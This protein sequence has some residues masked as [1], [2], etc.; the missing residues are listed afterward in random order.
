MYAVQIFWKA[1]TQHFPTI[2]MTQS[3]KDMVEWYLNIQVL[4]VYLYYCLS[5]ISATCAEWLKNTMYP[6]LYHLNKNE[7]LFKINELITNC[8]IFLWLQRI[9]YKQQEKGKIVL[10]S[11][12]VM[13]IR[14]TYEKCKKVRNILQTHM[15]KYE[16]HDIFMSRENQRELM[17]RLNCDNV[18]VPQVFADGQHLG[19]SA[20]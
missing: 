14:D 17:D 4:F 13:I 20:C 7:K 5:P 10:F 15:V 9:N 16:D 2:T 18:D 12:S 11:T 1:F 3:I 6:V 8:F 19:V